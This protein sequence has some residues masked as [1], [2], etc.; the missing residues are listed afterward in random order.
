MKY[1]STKPTVCDRGRGFDVSVINE[2]STR[3][4]TFGLFNAQQRIWQIGGRME[5]SAVPGKGTR[6]VVIAPPDGETS[7]P[8]KMEGSTNYHAEETIKECGPSDVCRVLIVDDHEVVRE[9]LAKM[10]RLASDLK[11]VGKAADGPQAIELADK[12]DPDVILMDVTL[13]EMSGAEAT[14]RILANN[15]KAKVI[16]LSIHNDAG[17][18]E[19]MRQAGAIA[20]LSKSCHS[21]DVLDTIRNCFNN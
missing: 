4:N 19:M 13:G 17:V 15:P 16:G 1:G 9:G 21:N 20:Y 12:L 18:I 11:L 3:R 14:R 8:E 7:I 6:I 2:G 5:I 10:L